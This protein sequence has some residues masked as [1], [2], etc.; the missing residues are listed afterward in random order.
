MEFLK[1]GFKQ[2]NHLYTSSKT[3]VAG[4]EVYVK[5]ENTYYHTTMDKVEGKLTAVK[6]DPSDFGER[7]KLF[8]QKDE[9]SCY[10][11]EIP[12]V[13][14]DRLNDWACEIAK[15]LPNLKLG[16]QIE[17]SANTSNMDKKG[18]PYKNLYISQEGEKVQWAFPL[19]DI[20]PLSKKFNKL[21][22]ADVYNSEDRDAFLYEKIKES[23][24]GFKKE[25][26]TA[27][28]PSDYK[29]S[30][31]KPAADIDLSGE[32]NDDLPF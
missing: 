29:T 15:F 18:Y 4:A 11:L 14:K 9:N 17:I 16:K 25:N 12:T 26:K 23:V 24:E 3:P 32:D 13:N 28:T 30:T 6:L 2:G 10:I 8:I 19:T 27:H 1:V 31:N 22:N 7:L 5:D 20:P 21:K